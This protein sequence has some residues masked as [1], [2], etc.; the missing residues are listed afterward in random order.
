MD[1]KK[2]LK[3]IIDKKNSKICLAADVDSLEELYKLI[4]NL[5]SKISV[6]K[7]HYD[8]ISD[9]TKDLNITIETLKNYKKKYNFLI[10]EDSKFADIGYVLDKKINNH[11]SIWADLISIHPIAGIESLKIVKNIGIILIGEMSTID[12]LFNKEYKNKVVRIAENLK[13]V[14]GIVCQHK[15][16]NSLLNITPGI[17]LNN[18][19][20]NLGQIYN[21]PTQKSFSDLYVIGRAIY[22]SPSPVSALDMF[23]DVIRKQN[24]K[25][26]SLTVIGKSIKML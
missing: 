10:W 22:R 26:N 2:K 24:N 6:L 20:D 15:M 23:L 5:G 19:K 16:S 18:S 4:E 17:S 8:I 25:E 7:I 12:N 13:N 14:V 11:I 21:N 3:D 9:F 1:Y